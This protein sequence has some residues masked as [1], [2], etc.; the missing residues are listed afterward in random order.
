M[1]KET[2]LITGAAGF[3]GSYLSSSLLKKGMTVVGVDNLNQ[4]YDVKLKHYRLERLQDYDNFIFI[5]EDIAN[6]SQVLDVFVKYNLSDIVNLIAKFC[7][8]YVIKIQ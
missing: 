6:K 8:R 1:T 2:Y 5:E 4:Y 7:V 3:I